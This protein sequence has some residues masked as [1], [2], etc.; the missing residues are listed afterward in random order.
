[1]RRLSNQ[2]KNQEKNHLLESHNWFRAHLP[3]LD[4][5]GRSLPRAAD[6]NLLMVWSTTRKLGCAMGEN[7]NYLVCNYHPQGNEVEFL[8]GTGWQK[9]QFAQTGAAC[10]KCDTG[11]GW[12]WENLCVHNLTSD[13]GLNSTCVITSCESG[14]R[15]GDCTCHCP[16]HRMGNRC[17]TPCRDNESCSTLGF[18]ACSNLY[19]FESCPL[20]CRRC[21]TQHTRQSAKSRSPVRPRTGGNPAER[22][23]AEGLAAG[24]KG[25]DARLSHVSQA[26]LPTQ[27]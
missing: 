19:V 21:E 27:N 6:M 1:A 9:T 7:C 12:C 2:E 25:E 11:T 17:E 4:A 20:L 24:R 3:G 15:V 14:G 23:R 13:E 5:K 8:P 10:T 26:P 16:S 22:R 18:S